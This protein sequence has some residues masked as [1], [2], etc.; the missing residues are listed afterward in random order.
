MDA[1]ISDEG[2]EEEFDQDPPR[3]QDQYPEEWD[4]DL[5][6]DWASEEEL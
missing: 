6:Y 2:L 5:S 3:S 4:T 1:E